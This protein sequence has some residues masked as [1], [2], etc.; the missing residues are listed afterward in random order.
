M[1]PIPGGVSTLRARL[2]SAALARA[3]ARAGGV[4]R[5]RH[6]SRSSPHGRGQPAGASMADVLTCQPADATK[7]FEPAPVWTIF[8]QLTRTGA[9]PPPWRPSGRRLTHAAT[10]APLRQLGIPRPSK[11]E[12][13]VLAW[14]KQY[15][16]ARGLEWTEDA[17]HNLVVRRPGTGGGEGA[18]AVVIQGHVDIVCE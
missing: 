3:A 7:G 17:V 18:P 6:R 12:E 1:L 14:I 5:P 10:A 9:R 4:P 8:E 15:A 2:P 16:D 13:Q 11:H